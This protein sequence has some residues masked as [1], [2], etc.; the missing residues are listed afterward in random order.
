MVACFV[1]LFLIPAQEQAL[2][3]AET[4]QGLFLFHPGLVDLLHGLLQLFTG[5][6]EGLL[7][8]LPQ[9]GEGAFIFLPG[10]FQPKGQCVR[11]GLP[12]GIGGEQLSLI[13]I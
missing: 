4:A 11:T 2:H 1:L 6:A 12:M 5:G 7:L 9:G 10:F 3:Q 13:H 8:G